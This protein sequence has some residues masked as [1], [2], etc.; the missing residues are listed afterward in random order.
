MVE[1]C[2]YSIEIR[3]LNFEYDRYYLSLE[4]GPQDFLFINDPEKTK[5]ISDISPYTIVPKFSIDKIN[6]PILFQIFNIDYTTLI[7]QEKKEMEK[8]EEINI[9]INT[10]EID[11]N[12]NEEENINNNNDNNILT[13]EKEKLYLKSKNMREITLLLKS[14]TTNKIVFSFQIRYPLFQDFY[15]YLGE[16]PSQFKIL[17]FPCILLQYESGSIITN[18][19]QQKKKSIK[20]KSENL[21]D[22]NNTNELNSGYYALKKIIISKKNDKLYDEEINYAIK[23]NV[24]EQIFINRQ[25]PMKEK[26]KNYIILKNILNIK[27]TYD[28]TLFA[29]EEKKRELDKKKL[30]LKKLIEK[31]NTLMNQRKEV[32]LYEKKIMLNKNSWNRLVTLKEILN[33]INTYTSEVILLKEKKIAQSYGIIDKYKKDIEEKK[34]KKIRDLQKINKGLQ[35]SNLFLIK[36]AINEIS[37]FFFNKKINIYKAFPSF[38]N[39]NKNNLIQ[40]KKTVDEFYNSNYRE[41]STMF[42]N[43]IYLL[44]YMSKKFDIV[45]PFVLYYN[46]SKSMA[47]IS[48]G[49]KNSGID[50]YIKENERNMGLGINQN[51]NDVNIKMEIISKMINDIIMFFYSKGICSSKFKIDDI[52][53]K[54]RKKKNNMYLN[55]IKLNELFKEILGQNLN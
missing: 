2:F 41:I 3:D 39:M 6:T 8:K 30:E 24:M 42:G 19:N 53:N 51:E 38:Y 28:S 23:K 4:E 10:N 47:F 52:N 49:A 33:K 9:N 54:K 44:T 22:I 5:I 16:K 34:N 26:E 11:I 15:T 36:Y 45:F 20:N 12:N 32:P 43:I 29:L 48:M 50:L 31:R 55:L 1:N 17:Q 14:Y 27:V 13:K 37:F 25:K 7:K 46:G 40:N 35:I 21:K 18:I